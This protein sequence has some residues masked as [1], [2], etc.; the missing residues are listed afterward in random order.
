MSVPVGQRSKSPLEVQVKADELVT[1]T[2]RIMS[3]D[4]VFDPKY[5]ALSD[6]VINAAVDALVCLGEA[7]DIMVN[8]DPE[9]WA[10]RRDLQREACRK[11]LTLRVLIRICRST[12]HLRK[13]KY[14]YWT[15][16][17]WDTL[18]LA[19]KWRDSDAKRYGHLSSGQ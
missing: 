3:N 1:H 11:L 12:Y 6:R 2:I 19:R 17:A 18:S 9:L 7:N 14:E 10:T 15:G 8:G 4:K 13:R 16:L 5:S